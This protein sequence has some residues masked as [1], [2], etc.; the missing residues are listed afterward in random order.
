M[1]IIFD[2]FKLIKGTGKSIGIYNVALELIT[3]LVLEQKTTSSKDI[4]NSEIVV[5]GNSINKVDFAMDGVEFHEI[6]KYDPKNKKQ[7]LYWELVYVVKVAKKLKGDRLFFPRGFSALNHSIKDIILVHDCIP[8]YYNE[9]FP[10]FFNKFENHY[11]MS[12]LKS[13]VKNSY[14]VITISESSKKDISHYCKRKTDDISVIYN[15]YKRVDFNRLKSCKED[16]KQYICAITS[17]LPHK[18]AEGIIRS[19][20]TYL[21]IAEKPLDLILIGVDQS[22][23]AKESGVIKTKVKCLKYIDSNDELYRIISRSSVFLFLSLIEGFGLPPIE[24]MQLKVPVICSNV[25]SLPEVVGDAAILVDPRDYL[26]VARQLD[27]V[28]TEEVLRADLIRKGLENIERFS[29]EKFAKSY[30]NTILG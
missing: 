28:I 29:G 4:V 24:A 1:R 27:K 11:I 3:Q 25:S 10:G 5:L 26:S 13:S 7:C 15:T 9:H 18:N 16:E 20:Q 14:K 23:I 6:T 30:W 8:F 21:E 12:R 2:C 19:Y 22:F 17:T